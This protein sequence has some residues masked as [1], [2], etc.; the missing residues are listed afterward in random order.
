MFILLFLGILFGFLL[1]ATLIE[2]LIIVLT[3]DIDE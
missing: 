1:L 3:G 2:C